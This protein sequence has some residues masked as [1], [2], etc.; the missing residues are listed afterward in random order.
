MEE[1]RHRLVVIRLR[2]YAMQ[3]IVTYVAWSVCL[4]V[5]A[6]Y[7]CESYKAAKPSMRYGYGWA[8]KTM[9]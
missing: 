6:G 8:Q 4:S 3:P 5:S 9:C 1:A 2:R 7:N